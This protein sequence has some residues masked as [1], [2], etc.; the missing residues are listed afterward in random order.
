[1]E[2]YPKKPEKLLNTLFIGSSMCIFIILGM[3]GLRMIPLSVFAI[4]LNLKPILVI[5][6][7]ILCKIERIT[8]KKIGYVTI[9][10]LGTGLIV[11]PGWFSHVVDLLVGNRV[12]T[13]EVHHQQHHGSH[14]I[15]QNLC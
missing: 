14:Y 8:W 13:S 6:I 15:F 1:V 7:E 12:R 9:S 10:F 4:I 11:D 2:F 3:N 5:L